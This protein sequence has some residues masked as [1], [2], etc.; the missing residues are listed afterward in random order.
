MSRIDVE[1]YWLER[2]KKCFAEPK[3]WGFFYQREVHKEEQMLMGLLKTFGFDSILEVGCGYGRVT[4]LVLRNF[5]KVK[6]MKA[7]DISPHQIQNARRYV[8]DKRVVFDL[9]NVKDMEELKW[10]DDENYDLVIAVSVLMHIPLEEIELA[11]KNMVEI[12]NKHIVNID[13]FRPTIAI[14]EGYCFAHDYT[15]LYKKFGIKEVQVVPITKRPSYAVSFGLDTGI[16]VFKDRGEM[17]C[18]W[19]AMK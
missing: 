13:W 12:S 1:D 16:R 4:K 9:G 10:K 2:G 19:H 7:I 8:T 5:P 11:I 3:K 15:R 6:K 18:I 17:R 14:Q